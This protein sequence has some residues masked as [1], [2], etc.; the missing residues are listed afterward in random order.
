MAKEKGKKEIKFEIK[1][2]LFHAAAGTAIALLA[3]FGADWKLFATLTAM[4]ALAVVA[5]TKAKLPVIGWFLDNFERK[6]AAFPGKGAFFM[7]LAATIAL[8]LFEKNIAAASMAILAIGDSVS[9]IAGRLFGRTKHPFNNRKLLEGSIAGFIAGAIAA[10]FF[11]SWLNA[12]V[13]SGIA[14]LVEGMELKFGKTVIDDN[15]TV[16]II[17]AVVIYIMQLSI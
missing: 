4:G 14:M 1:R 17:A 15:L 13:A 8:Y 12:A 10:S 2:K 9:N 11:V 16:P 6:N 7:L 5:S 3:A